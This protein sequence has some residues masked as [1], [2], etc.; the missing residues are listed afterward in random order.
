MSRNCSEPTW[1]PRDAKQIAFTA[2][3]GREFEI[4]LYEM[5]ASAAKILT[6]GRGDAVEPVWLSDG[7]HLLYTQRSK[8]RSRLA[9][10]DTLTGSQ[11]VLSPE[12]WGDCS[13]A[14]FA[15]MK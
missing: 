14:D 9:I 6:R 12:V 1:K 3:V 5:G 11:E 4:C 8:G 13:M 15:A 2:A 10:L 7:R